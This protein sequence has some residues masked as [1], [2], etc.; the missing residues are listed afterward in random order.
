MK[1]K[2]TE[3]LVSEQ[4]SQ[5][6]SFLNEEISQIEK[7]ETKPGWT[8]WALFGGISTCIWLLINQIEKTAPNWN[9]ISLMLI[10][11]AFLGI[12]FRIITKRLYRKNVSSENNRFLPLKQ[13]FESSRLSM[14]LSLLYAIIIYTLTLVSTKN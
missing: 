11:I 10:A 1:K 5:L 4:R 3:D 14:L 8:I 6:L 13:F 2:T 7:E 9:K 12:T